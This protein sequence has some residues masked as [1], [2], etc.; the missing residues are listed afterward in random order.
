MTDQDFM[1]WLLDSDAAPVTLVE[2]VAD[3]NG[4]DATLY[5]SS[6]PYVTGPAETPPNQA[7]L[8]V[9][10]GGLPITE[11][12]ALNGDAGL[13]FGDQELVNHDGSLD[14][15]LG[16]VWR[17]K[18]NR[19][20]IGDARWPR[21]AFRLVFDGLVD[22]LDP[23]K[24]R[25]TL[26]IKLRDKMQRLNAAVTE[27]KLGGT[28]PNAD[29]IVPVPFGEVHNQSPLLENS[30]TL[31]YR[32]GPGPLQI[33]DE[34]RDVGKPVLAS[35]DNATGRITLQSGLAPQSL[36]VSVAG[37][38]SAAGVYSNRISPLVQLIATE[39]GS[40][41]Q[42]FTAADLDAVNLAAFDA[43]HPQPVGLLVADNT[44]CFTAI[45]QLA[46]SVGAQP[47]MSATGKLRLIQIAL[48]A[49]GAVTDM[50]VH[51]MRE[52]TFRPVERLEVIG[53]VKVAFCRNWTVQTNMTTNLPAAHKDLY[54][55]EWLTRTVSDAAVL[56]RY[57]LDAD[58]EQRE[59]CLLVGADAQAEAQ[60]ELD[61]LKTQR[62]VYQFE[63]TPDMLMLEL[64]AAGRV[65]YP[66]YSLA[67]GRDSV[68]VMLAKNW[69][70]RR[71]TVG[72]MV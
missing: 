5:L 56:A 64:G 17:N 34:V 61:L 23:T 11:Q 42:R 21:A 66:R 32:V 16:Y 48:P 59:T 7:Y 72:V 10:G 58:P 38:K 24:D 60:R 20:W 50:T 36:T 54:A 28:S 53:A 35:V 26:N 49:S 29:S 13:V 30:A 68:V 41:P 15:W 40:A 2:V 8:P 37:V 71:V 51:S 45:K 46:A 1:A 44:S 65:T 47:I 6:A 55:T 33:I 69:Q 18:P 43:A 25:N 22:D 70:E 31:T 63:G 52:K 39:Y 62:T 67:A 14:A 3:I 19:Q 4:T 57:K 9:L 27:V 12:V